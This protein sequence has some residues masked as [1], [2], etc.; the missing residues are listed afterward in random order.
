MVFPRT[1]DR[2]RATGKGQSS[3]WA[4]LGPVPSEGEVTGPGRRWTWWEQGRDRASGHRDGAQEPWEGLGREQ[5]QSQGQREGPV[6]RKRGGRGRK[7]KGG[8][9]GTRT[10]SSAP[11]W[12]GAE[13]R[14]RRPEQEEEALGDAREQPPQA[15]GP[16]GRVARRRPGP[17][18][19]GSC[20]RSRKAENSNIQSLGLATLRPCHGGAGGAEGD[21]EAPAADSNPAH[22][23]RHVGAG[24]QRLP[25]APS[26]RPPD[27]PAGG[28]A[29]CLN[30]VSQRGGQS[31][32]QRSR[33]SPGR[34][35]SLEQLGPLGPLHGTAFRGDWML[36]GVGGWDACW[37][38]GFQGSLRLVLALEEL[39]VQPGRRPTITM[40]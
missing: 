15:R 20:C 37:T 1:R 22:S 39:L 12:R 10:L 11:R 4:G 40:T 26:A 16:G 2:L 24:P 36:A 6:R 32:G 38:Q 28:P 34:E 14:A 9:K 17:T 23:G 5:K 27:P 31:T 33:G 30:A 21:G 19:S 29:V 25:A 35:L 13:S 18:V 3:L 7:D 8:W